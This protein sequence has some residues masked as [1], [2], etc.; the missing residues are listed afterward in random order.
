LNGGALGMNSSGLSARQVARRP[1]V[2]LKRV[3]GEILVH[4]GSQRGFLGIG[5]LPVRFRPRS[6][7]KQ[8]RDAALLVVAVQPSSP[9]N[10]PDCC[11]AIAR[12][13]A[14]QNDAPRRR[15]LRRSR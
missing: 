3:V 5:T 1:D 9:P 8:P 11:W 6:V 10:T 12:R 7:R 15:S 14:R 13:V 2:V 4:G